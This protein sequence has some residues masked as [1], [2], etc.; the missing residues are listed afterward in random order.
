MTLRG[1]AANAA[2]TCHVGWIKVGQLSQGT[3]I[4]PA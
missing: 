4:Q 1:P 2:G 3:S